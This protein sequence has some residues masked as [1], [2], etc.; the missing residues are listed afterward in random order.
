MFLHEKKIASFALVLALALGLIML[1]VVYPNLKKIIKI[2]QE[3]QSLR[4]LMELKYEK[5]RRLNKPR[6]GFAAAQKI[7]AN[8]QTIFINRGAEYDLI[9][10]LERLAADLAL[11]P[12]ID[13]A[14]KE[15]PLNS[16]LYFL[17][18]TII[19]TGNWQNLMAYL[20]QLEKMR[21]VIGL[22]DVL[23]AQE[24]NQTTL[25]VKGRLYVK[26]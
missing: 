11:S 14:S 19:T 6:L 3:A 18:L 17:N 4:Q 2:R 16:E 20:N 26:K 22:A 10:N 21:V 5:I 24:E 23:I 9:N 7:I 1:L 12:K 13:L 15:N 25:T 8:N